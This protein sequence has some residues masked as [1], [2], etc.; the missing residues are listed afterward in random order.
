MQFGQFMGISAA[1]SEAVIMT[2]AEVKRGND[3]ISRL[4]RMPQNGVTVYSG[5][6]KSRRVIMVW[7]NQI[8]RK[9]LFIDSSAKEL[10]LAKSA[11]SQPSGGDHRTK[12]R[13]SDS[14]K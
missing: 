1:A 14:A 10:A 3:S 13:G 2:G 6:R 8:N 9:A 12:R 5:V 4:S 7:S 11:V